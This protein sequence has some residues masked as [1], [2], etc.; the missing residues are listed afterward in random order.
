MEKTVSAAF[1]HWQ[2]PT[3][4]LRLILSGVGVVA[5]SGLDVPAEAWDPE[6]KLKLR[7][8]FSIST[9]QLKC[10]SGATKAPAFGTKPTL[11]TLNL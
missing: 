6:T 10:S 1:I 4:G 7:T 11:F 2:F 5:T 8:R 3:L 9:K